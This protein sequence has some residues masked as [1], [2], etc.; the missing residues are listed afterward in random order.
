MNKEYSCLLNINKFKGGGGGG[1]G[2]MGAE[3]YN[4][5]IT[6]FQCRKIMFEGWNKGFT[7]QC[8]SNIIKN[9]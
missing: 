4:R 2:G 3:I 5:K 6:I 8:L 9:S 1:G 7:T